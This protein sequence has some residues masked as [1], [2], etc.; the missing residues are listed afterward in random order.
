M[1]ENELIPVWYSEFESHLSE[2]Q[3]DQQLAYSFFPINADAHFMH[4]L[5][6][7]FA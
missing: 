1:S 7:S 3:N 2:W 5:I 6:F 4:C